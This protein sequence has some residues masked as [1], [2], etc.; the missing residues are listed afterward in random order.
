MTRRF[1]AA[2]ALVG[3]MLLGSAC[4]GRT[5][6]SAAIDTAVQQQLRLDLLRLASAAAAH[7]SGAARAALETF[8]ADTALAHAAGKV[9]DAKL[10]ELRAAA[11]SVQTDL[12]SASAGAVAAPSRSAT[13]PASGTGPAPEP[14]KTHGKG[15]G[16]GNGDGKGNGGGNG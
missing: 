10:A 1:C 7:D 13:S 9:T 15:N 8:N 4:G 14:A 5:T 6:A 3:A 2:A 16:N 11:G 12:A